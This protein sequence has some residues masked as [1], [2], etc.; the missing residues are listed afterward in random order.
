[1]A[2]ISLDISYTIDFYNRAISF[3][4]ID[5]KISD[6]D[7]EEDIEKQLKNYNT[8]ME[9]ASGHITDYLKSKVN[10]TLAKKEENGG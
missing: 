7:L 4:K 9:L 10:K 8:A 6:L 3:G 1:M 5:A 2:K